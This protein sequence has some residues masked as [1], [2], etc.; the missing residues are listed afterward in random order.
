MAR[1]RRG[2]RSRRSSPCSFAPEH[3]AQ[4]LEILHGLPDAGPHQSRPAA[5][6]RTAASCSPPKPAALEEL[7]RRSLPLHGSRRAAPASTNSSARSS[8]FPRPPS[9]HATTP[10]SCR[11]DCSSA[12]APS[13]ARG[14]TTAIPFIGEKA[15]KR[16]LE[17]KLARLGEIEAA[18][19][20]LEPVEREVE[21][22]IAARQQEIPDHT[23]I[24]PQNWSASRNCRATAGQT[25][26][27]AW[28]N[29]C[30]RHRRVRRRSAT[31]SRN[32]RSRLPA[33][34]TRK[35][36]S[37]ARA[38]HKDIE[39]A[40][41]LADPTGASPRPRARTSFSRT[42]LRIDIVRHH[43]RYRAWK[44]EVADLH[45]APDVRAREFAKAAAA[46]ELAAIETTG[47]LKVAMLDFKK[48][49]HPKFDDLPEDGTDA[50][51]LLNASSKSSR[52]R[53]FR[54]TSAS[55]PPSASA[56]N[57][58]SARRCSAACSRRSRMSK[59]SSRCST[60]S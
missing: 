7:P 24:S 41:K 37:S 53:T 59:T 56:G 47:D 27:A 35:T 20:R 39:Q 19:R 57:R 28:P 30:H 1:R 12:A 22:L 14:P 16:Q 10:R 29:T 33:G 34:S 21:R 8:G 38:A 45:P 18:L 26:E 15:C 5:P 3:H 55:P 51:R 49:F 32:S 6:D 40:E 11:T 60:S 25:R 4:A 31:G 46:A 52:A 13:P 44:Q 17:M 54:N 43:D 50:A 2:R 23:E 48:T 36:P 42:K 9:F 58:S